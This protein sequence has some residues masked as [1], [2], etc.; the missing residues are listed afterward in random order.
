MLH[1]ILIMTLCGEP[2]AFSMLDNQGYHSGYV[3]EASESVAKRVV[4]LMN[5]SA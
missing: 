4:D 3:S 1:F 2:E 5:T